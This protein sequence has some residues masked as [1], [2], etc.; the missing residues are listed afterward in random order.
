[1]ELC[2]VCHHRYYYY[3]ITINEQ[4]PSTYQILRRIEY[5]F[6]EV[7]R[8]VE[9]SVRIKQ[10]L[11]DHARL[12]FLELLLSV[13]S[14]WRK[15][16]CVLNEGFSFGVI[17]EERWWLVQYNCSALILSLLPVVDCTGKCHV[18]PTNNLTP[19]VLTTAAAG[20]HGRSY[21]QQGACCTRST[22]DTILVRI[23]SCND[24]VRQYAHFAS[25]TV[26]K[27]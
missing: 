15:T 10:N 8:V 17:A 9:I 4:L 21:V 7:V 11:A 19:M 16:D 26:I 1:M 3:N 20:R 27:S 23:S 5:F 2:R 14:F 25:Y 12:F 18:S 13:F 22:L 6:W 24:T